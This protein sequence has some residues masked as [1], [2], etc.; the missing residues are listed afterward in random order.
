MRIW[1]IS[2]LVLLFSGI[3]TVPAFS[4]EQS[5]TNEVVLSSFIKLEAP[6]LTQSAFSH[7]DKC[8]NN[9]G[10]KASS[11]KVSNCAADC[12]SLVIDNTEFVFQTSIELETTPIPVFSTVI[13]YPKEQ[14]PKFS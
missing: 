3:T 11:N 10:D 13:V 7:H 1:V 4:I 8:C 5:D 6:A 2:L 12:T 9:S 14:P